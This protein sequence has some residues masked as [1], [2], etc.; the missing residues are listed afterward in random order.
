MLVEATT[1]TEVYVDNDWSGSTGD[2]I[3]DVN[4]EIVGN[5]LGIFGITAFASINAALGKV[6]TT[7]TVYV[8]DG[9]YATED[10]D[11]TT[12]QT[13]T[14][15]N[16][17]L[18]TGSTVT[19]ASPRIIWRGHAIPLHRQEALSGAYRLERPASPVPSRVGGELR[20]APR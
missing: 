1:P 4:P 6:T 3:T 2:F 10:I 8:N 5:Q 16:D 11:L 12:N 15:L 20:L 9:T 17:P 18:S 7:G 14:L 13:I 19:V